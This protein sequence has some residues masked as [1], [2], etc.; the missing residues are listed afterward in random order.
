MLRWFRYRCALRRRHQRARGVGYRAAAVGSD[1]LAAARR[2]GDYYR[3]IHLAR[4]LA[5]LDRRLGHPIDAAAM[6]GIASL[7]IAEA[8]ERKGHHVL[9]LLVEPFDPQAAAEISKEPR[10]G[11]AVL[12]DVVARLQWRR[13]GPPARR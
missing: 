12:E 10:L 3:A 6:D 9:A 1:R 5:R 2:A 13:T 4:V 11:R 7:L 8:R